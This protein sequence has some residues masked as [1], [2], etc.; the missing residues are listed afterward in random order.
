MAVG[1]LLHAC[2]TVIQ[3][4]SEL[5]NGGHT[6]MSVHSGNLC[7]YLVGTRTC[8]WAGTSRVFPLKL[9][10]LRMSVDRKLIVRNVIR[11]IY[12]YCPAAILF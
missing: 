3:S 1:C 6:S 5:G 10:F 2:H 11:I 4:P 9:W 7:D 12:E 8:R